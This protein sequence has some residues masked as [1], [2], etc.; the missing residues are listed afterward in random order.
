MVFYQLVLPCTGFLVDLTSLQLQMILCLF[1]SYTVATSVSNVTMSSYLCN[2]SHYLCLRLSATLS[3]LLL[4]PS[5]YQK[6]P[7]TSPPPKTMARQHLL[8]PIAPVRIAQVYR[9]RR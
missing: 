1:S 7:S 6:N 5:P 3:D 8:A 9:R 2:M 4:Q